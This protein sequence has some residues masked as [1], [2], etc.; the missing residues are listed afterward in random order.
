MYSTAKDPTCIAAHSTTAGIDRH[1]AFISEG[2]CRA[3][4]AHIWLISMTMAR[5]PWR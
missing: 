3:F 4:S 1:N 2:Y 5:R